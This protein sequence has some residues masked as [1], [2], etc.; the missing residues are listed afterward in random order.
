MHR[1]NVEGDWGDG[2]WGAGLPVQ[3]G[4]VRALR[5][6]L[7][8]PL[9]TARSPSGSGF[10]EIWG[11]EVMFEL[12]EEIQ[13]GKKKKTEFIFIF[14]HRTCGQKKKKSYSKIS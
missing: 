12:M 8:W 13:M 6:G 9:P 3:R 11:A 2:P 10:Q 1:N 5:K 4:A 14:L 7:G